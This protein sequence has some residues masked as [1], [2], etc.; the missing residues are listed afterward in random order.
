M[1]DIVLAIVP[2]LAV[3]LP[4]FFWACTCCGAECTACVDDSGPDEWEFTFAN[5]INNGCL[6]CD[7]FN[8]TH[9]VQWGGPLQPCRWFSVADQACSS[10]G[11]LFMLQVSLGQIS[12]ILDFAPIGA[13]LVGT[14]IKFGGS[15]EQDCFASHVLTLS[16]T[17]SN[18]CKEDGN[19]VLPASVTINPV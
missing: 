15:P 4:M 6:N 12:L 18:K 10:N 14:Y 16:S 13:A 11:H 19:T 5:I 1:L 2:Q 7:E 9:R 3:M 8:G 17:V